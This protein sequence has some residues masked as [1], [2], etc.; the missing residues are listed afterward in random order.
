[1]ASTSPTN[2][3]HNTTGEEETFLDPN[4]VNEEY[5]EYHESGDHPM[6]DDEDGQGEDDDDM[7]D[8]EVIVDD[9]I[10]GFFLHTSPVYSVALHGNW[11]VTGG[12]DD[13]GYVW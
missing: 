10:Q 7:L 1:M 5:A 13:L 6:S 11:A 12:G 9:S 2:E 4:E 8:E 3:E